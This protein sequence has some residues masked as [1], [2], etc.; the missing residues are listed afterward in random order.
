MPP[1]AEPHCSHAYELSRSRRCHSKIA[2]PIWLR[3]TPSLLTKANVV[4]HLAH[5][6]S[7]LSHTSRR[8]CVAPT[9]RSLMT[10]TSSPPRTRKKS[11]LSSR[12]QSVHGMTPSRHLRSEQKDDL[13]CDACCCACTTARIGVSSVHPPSNACMP[14]RSAAAM[15]M[16]RAE[17][18][19]AIWVRWLR[20]RRNGTR[21]V[22][23][24]WT[25]SPQWW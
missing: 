23:H 6:F 8:D 18:G 17:G 1:T 12:Q 7:T 4:R 11:P 20:E 16:G 14:T 15:P 21:E 13:G 2:P 25:V 22:E 5:H 9:T 3:P 24:L 19:S 10:S